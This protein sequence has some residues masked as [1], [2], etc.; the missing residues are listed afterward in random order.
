MTRSS[1]A[2]K[3]TNLYLPKPLHLLALAV[4]L[5]GSGTINSKREENNCA[6]PAQIL[7]PFEKRLLREQFPN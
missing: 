6:L 3:S 7:E 2:T 5:V 4:K 1:S